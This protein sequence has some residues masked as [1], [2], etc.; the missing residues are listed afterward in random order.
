MALVLDASPQDRQR[1][2]SA[3]GCGSFAGPSGL[4]TQVSRQRVAVLV[5]MFKA[6]QHIKLRRDA[7]ELI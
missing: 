1:R 4:C 7:I 2:G 3:T 6:E 5:L